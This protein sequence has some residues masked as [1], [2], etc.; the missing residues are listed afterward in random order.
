MTFLQTGL[1]YCFYLLSGVKR[2]T[3]KGNEESSKDNY[4]IGKGAGIT[5]MELAPQ[6]NNLDNISLC[7]SVGEE[8]GCLSRILI[9]IHPGP[10]NSNKSEGGKNL[11]S[12]IFL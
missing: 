4:R 6:S 8:P 11:W 7:Y 10:N 5:K 2:N 12:I 1:S 3:K 9:F